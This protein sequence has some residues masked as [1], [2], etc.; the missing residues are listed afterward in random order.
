MFCREGE[1]SVCGGYVDRF[2]G[3]GKVLG[4]H[5]VVFAVSCISS[6]SLV[7]CDGALD[8]GMVAVVDTAQAFFVFFVCLA[9]NSIAD[10]YA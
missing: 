2:A 10:V 1:L 8:C 3:G 6:V 9:R 7:L 5:L 4:V